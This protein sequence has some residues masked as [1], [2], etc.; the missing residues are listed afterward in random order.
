[1]FKVISE[2]VIQAIFLII[3]ANEIYMHFQEKQMED[4]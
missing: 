2:L 4:I 1:M 3:R